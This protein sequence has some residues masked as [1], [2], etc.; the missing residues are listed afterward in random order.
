MLCISW[1]RESI[2]GTL[3][4]LRRPNRPKR[5]SADI[6]TIFPVDIQ[7]IIFSILFGF[8]LLLRLNINK[9][10]HY[11]VVLRFNGFAPCAC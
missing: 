8:S 4:A 1:S 10:L 3:A 11:M 6:G 2:L 5:S 9:I 7:F